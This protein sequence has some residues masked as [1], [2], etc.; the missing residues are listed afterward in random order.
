[1]SK[2]TWEIANRNLIYKS[3]GELSDEDAWALLNSAVWFPTNVNWA[4]IN[5]N[6]AGIKLKNVAYCKFEDFCKKRSRPY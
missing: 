5:V 6:W 1:M 2:S 4:G 3:W